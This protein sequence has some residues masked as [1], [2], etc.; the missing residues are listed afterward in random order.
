M[1]QIIS[2]GVPDVDPTNSVL[3]KVEERIKQ[4]VQNNDNGVIC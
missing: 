1:F 3:E 4:H 2:I